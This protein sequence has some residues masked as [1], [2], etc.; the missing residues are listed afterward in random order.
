[1]IMPFMLNFTASEC[2]CRSI[3]GHLV[4]IHTEAD[5]TALESTVAQSGVK[6]AVW[7]GESA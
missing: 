2:F 6:S 5:Y 7:L 4:S 3:G 1:M